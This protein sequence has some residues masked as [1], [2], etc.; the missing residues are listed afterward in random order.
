VGG[1]VVEYLFQ[2]NEISKGAFRLG[3][4]LKIL[5]L[6]GVQGIETNLLDHQSLH[7]AVEGVDTIYSMA[8]PMPGSDDDFERVN[9]KGISNLL[10]VA[11]EMGVRSIVHLSTIDVYG[12]GAGEVTEG[13]VPAPGNPYQTAKLAAD[14]LLL[15]FSKRNQLPK[16][17]I[18]RAVKAVGSRDSTLVIPILRMAETGKVVVPKGKEMSF[19]HPKDIAQAM[20]KAATST[21]VPPG[22]YLV[23]SFDTN[24]EILAAEVV[25]SAGSTAPVKLQGLLSKSAIPTYALQQLEASLRLGLPSDNR[26]LGF[27]PE[28]DLKKTCEEIAAWYKKEPWVTEPA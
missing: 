22:I 21:E 12:F 19:I 4:H 3:S 11:Q 7:E 24:P 27:S 25:R 1:H 15:D 13:T 9:T 6:N 20:Y 17:V 5:D 2:Q 14:T 10:E 23:K 8:S 18:I 16:V 28:F 26:T